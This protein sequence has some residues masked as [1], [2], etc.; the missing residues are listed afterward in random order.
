MGGFAIA[1]A[2]LIAGWWIAST[3]DDLATATDKLSDTLEPLTWDF[4]TVENQSE[5]R[6]E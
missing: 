2:I 6:A 5:E 4:S 3:I 1:V